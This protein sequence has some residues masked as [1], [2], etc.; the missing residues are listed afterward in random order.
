MATPAITADLLSWPDI[1]HQRWNGILVGNGA[2]RAVWDSFRYSSLLEKAKSQDIAHPLTG[3][4]LHVFTELDTENF[5][6]VL[7]AVAT[8]ILV[9]RSYGRDIDDLRARYTS[10]RN[11]LVEA[12]HAVHVPWTS[13][14]DEIR[15]AIRTELRNYSFVYSTNYDLL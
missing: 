8:S 7:A 6:R 1:A 15:T 13:V 12:V 10:I 9:C 14:S 11:A 4:D 2:S 3:E 5:E